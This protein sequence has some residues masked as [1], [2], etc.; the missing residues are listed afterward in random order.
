[1]TIKMNEVLIHTI[2][3]MNSENMF[4]EEVR[5]KRFHIVQFHLYAILRIGKSIE[6]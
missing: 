1:M 4:C 2:I 5:H 3:W 6:T